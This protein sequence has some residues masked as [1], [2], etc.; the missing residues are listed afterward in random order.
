MKKHKYKS[1]LLALTLI[2]TIVSCDTEYKGNSSIAGIAVAN[3][4]FSMKDSGSRWSC[5]VLK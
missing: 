2:G 5:R 1:A 3:P 4:N